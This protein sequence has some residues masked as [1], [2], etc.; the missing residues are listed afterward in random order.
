MSAYATLIVETLEGV[1]LIRLNRPD[2]LN[3]LNGELLSELGQALDVAE[4][5]AEVRCVVLTSTSPK[6]A[7]IAS[8]RNSPWAKF[9]TSIRPKISERPTAIRA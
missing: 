9:T 5:D 7:Y 2:A 4:A 8:I 6:V 1:S 3:A